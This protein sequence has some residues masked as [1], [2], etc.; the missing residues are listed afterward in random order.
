M[1]N[2]GSSRI[3]W[4]ASHR[5]RQ[6]Y[7]RRRGQ[8]A[9]RANGVSARCTIAF[10]SGKAR[11][12]TSDGSATSSSI[13]R[14]LNHSSGAHA[15]QERAFQASAATAPPQT[16][17]ASARSGGEAEQCRRRQRCLQQRSTCVPDAQ[18]GARSIR[19]ATHPPPGRGASRSAEATRPRGI[20]RAT[21][22]RC[23]NQSISMPS[24]ANPKGPG[25]GPSSARWRAHRVAV[26][27]CART[28]RGRARRARFR[29]CRPQ[30]SPD[31]ARPQPT[32]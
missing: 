4:R 11:P 18:S 1:R 25:P 17:S 28:R 29:T 5:P 3:A 20:R 30:Q 13:G 23:R 32:A 16:A 12:A 31:S 26:G 6:P 24:A 14:M 8:P 2:R 9:R 15:W 10:A 7:S 19:R 21:R 27:P 22:A